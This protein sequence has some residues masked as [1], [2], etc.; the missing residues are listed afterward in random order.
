[1]GHPAYGDSVE[2]ANKVSCFP[3]HAAMKQRH[4]WAPTH[5]G[6]EHDCHSYPLSSV[7]NTV[8]LVPDAQTT[9]PPIE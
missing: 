1:M 9:P 5:G 3:T 2:G 8:P 7:R 6:T 4:G